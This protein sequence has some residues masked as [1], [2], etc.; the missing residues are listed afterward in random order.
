MP[1]T[2][3]VR[4]PIRPWRA[5]SARSA[6]TEFPYRGKATRATGTSR[7]SSSSSTA[8]TRVFFPAPSTPSTAT[9]M[10]VPAQYR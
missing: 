8:V 1:W 2:D 7:A 6:W 9:I 4:S 5:A 10:P 3:P